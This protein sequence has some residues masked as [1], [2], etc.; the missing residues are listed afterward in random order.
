M[1]VIKSVRLNTKVYMKSADTTRNNTNT[2]A[3]DPDLSIPVNANQNIFFLMSLEL[4][5]ST[6][7]D[8]K[9]DITIPAGGALYKR[10]AGFPATTVGIA[11]SDGTTGWD[12]A[13]TTGTRYRYDNLYHYIGGANGGSITLQWAQNTKHVSDC[14]LKEGSCFI[15]F[16]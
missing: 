10:A 8:I 15:V 4:L 12:L 11:D 7:G 9:F 3:N 2:L 14:I 6:E 16:M 13:T 1:P 5:A